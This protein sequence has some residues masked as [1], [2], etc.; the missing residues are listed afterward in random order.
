MSIHLWISS[1]KRGHTDNVIRSILR[2]KQWFSIKNQYILPC[3]SRRK[4]NNLLAIF[5]KYFTKSDT[6]SKYSQKIK[7]CA[8]CL[9][10]LHIDKNVHATSYLVVNFEPYTRGKVKR[11]SHYSYLTLC[12]GS[13]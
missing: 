11:F 13:L 6:H 1:H 4:E 8:C 5:R 9:L 12:G 2:E 3:I 7:K 10:K